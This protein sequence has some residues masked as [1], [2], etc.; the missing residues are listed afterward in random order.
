MIKLQQDGPLAIVRIDRGEKRNAF[1]QALIAELRRVAMDLRDSLDIH[2]IVLTGTREAFSAGMDLEDEMWH[3]EDKTDLERRELYYTG[4]RLCE[5]WEALP[6]LTIAA[7]DGF[8]VGAGVALSLA[9]DWRVL[10]EDA[11]LYVPEV[12][13]GINLQWGAVPRL[14]S[15][16]GPA[17]A[18]RIC[19]L[20]EKLPA[21]L[22]LDWGLVDHLAPPGEAVDKATA[23]AHAVCEFPAVTVRMVKEA[24]NA[25]AGGGRRAAAFADADQSQ[26]SGAFEEAV[27]ARQAF[28][29]RREL[30]R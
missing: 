25:A 28:L 23:L 10:A 6:Q 24:I 26:L 29:A 27:A 8:A 14:V 11:F 1:N 9:C 7:I 3:C 20:C 30:D 16:V 17:R 2:A 19:L 22:A 13:I 12:K 15:L 5:A 21:A 4:V 18:K